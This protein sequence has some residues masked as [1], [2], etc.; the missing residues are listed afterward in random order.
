M[1]TNFVGSAAR[2]PE[3]SCQPWQSEPEGMAAPG[4][5]INCPGPVCCVPRKSTA[6]SRRGANWGLQLE[7]R[8]GTEQPTQKSSARVVG[9]EGPSLPLSPAAAGTG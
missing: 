5:T 9:E 2:F 8:A 4:R 3:F 6:P 7:G 1:A